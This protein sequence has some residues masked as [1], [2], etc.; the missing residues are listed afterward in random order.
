MNLILSCL[1]GALIVVSH[2]QEVS[3]D[4]P[5][6][7]ARIDARRRVRSGRP[8]VGDV[9]SYVRKRQR[10]RQEAA[11]AVAGGA[12]SGQRM[13]QRLMRTI[14]DAER[15]LTPQE[16]AAK[17]SRTGRVVA[18]IDMRRRAQEGFRRAAAAAL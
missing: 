3:T 14:A 7:L 4:L 8:S 9:A 11:Q 16:L 6:V 15:R 2:T 17:R 5:Q 13:M 12:L 10:A 1:C 18:L